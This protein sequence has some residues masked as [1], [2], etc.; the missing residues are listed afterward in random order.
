M[1]LAIDTS[2]EIAS[3]ALADKGKILAKVSWHCGQNQTIQLLPRLE[4]LLKRNNLHLESLNA[5]IVAT[6]P[7]S[8][9]G[10]R[11]GISTAKGLAL[12]MDIPLIGLSTLE[13]IA[14]R[15]AGT[16][17]PVCPIIDVRRNEI[18]T[19]IFKKQ[20]GSWLRIKKEHITTLEALYPQI[21]EKTVFCGDYIPSVKDELLNKL[22]AKAVVA[23]EAA[24]PGLATVLISLGAKRLKSGD[25]DQP[26]SLQPLY[27][28]QPA[29]TKPRK[30]LGMSSS[31][32]KAV[33]WDMDG[34]IVD[35]APFHLKAWQQVF[36]K[37]G[38]SFR[39]GDF[40]K[41]FGR[42]NDAIIKGVLGEKAS[43]KVITTIGNEKE[44]ALR[45]K[46]SADLKP[47]SGVLPLMKELK[48][49]GV[50]M[51]VASSAPVENIKLVLNILK[52][53]DD[54]PVIISEQDVSK[55]KPDPQGFL[56]AAKRL[57]ISPGNC[58]VIEDAVSGIAAAKKAGMGCIAVS[59]SHPAAS[60]KQADLVVS[61]LAE[62]SVKK[63]ESIISKSRVRL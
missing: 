21:K 13:A 23:T 14:Y 58:L 30:A 50:K 1:Q 20:N 46:I 53:T 32:L 3:L 48:Q 7:G 40:R 18:A 4:Q 52:L 9:N 17:L 41:T 26:A 59:N 54:L 15:H 56:L 47:L 35:S 10:L 43:L 33:I 12:G 5:I 31:G 8:Y 39:E 22:G 11:V 29:I 25:Y 55:G 28:R 49:R 36:G 63:I 44:A 16:G 60:L 24:E 62:V 38:I 42:R 2:A 45:D 27:L 61:S 51:A 19:A 34:V 57:G 6:G 37:R